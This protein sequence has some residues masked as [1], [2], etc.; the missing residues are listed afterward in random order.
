MATTM[1]KGALVV[2][3]KLK[4]H[5]HYKGRNV[6][7]GELLIQAQN[8]SDPEYIRCQFSY[9]LDPVNRIVTKTGTEDE[10]DQGLTSLQ[11]ADIR[12]KDVD[13]LATAMNI[14]VKLVLKQLHQSRPPMAN[15]LSQLLRCEYGPLHTIL[16]VGEVT[17]E[18][19]S[20]DLVIPDLRPR[21]PGDLE[22]EIPKQTLYYQQTK[23]LTQ[24][25]DDAERKR[26]RVEKFDVVFTSMS[27][28][29]KLIDRLVDVIV[30]YNCEKTYNL[31][32]CNCQHFTRDALTALGYED[33]IRFRGKM[34]DYFKQLK[35]GK[36]TVPDEY[37]T[38]ESLD[39]YVK[40][41]LHRI[42]VPDME[43]LLCQ[44]FQH[45]LPS[46]RQME[47]EDLDNWK[48]DVE[49]CQSEVLDLKVKG[50]S[51]FRVSKSP[52]TKAEEAQLEELQDDV[53]DEVCK[54]VQC[55]YDPL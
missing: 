51:S 26:D 45:H 18:W 5:P 13:N 36:L 9:L 29:V 54:C 48:C 44:Y 42:T 35:A 6:P 50:R 12:W 8:L 52:K 10:L 25:L 39:D 24:A 7:E 32:K 17:I 21:L 19:G 2:L 55:T 53:P 30:T 11:T 41:N 4:K 46:M 49:D 16:Q 28:K 14:P 27:E 23:Q 22:T 43:Y 38:H 3:E 31:F 34:N 47:G 37:A 33:T 20:D 1:S 15:K 40:A